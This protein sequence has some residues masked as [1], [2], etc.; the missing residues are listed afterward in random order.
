M[1]E[2]ENLNNKEFYTINRFS[3]TSS[4]LSSNIILS[5]KNGEKA[6]EDLRQKVIIQNKILN[7]YQSWANTLVDILSEQEMTNDHLDLGTPIQERLENIQNLINE[8]LEIKKKIIEHI[9]LNEKLEN[10]IKIKKWNLNNCVKDFNCGDKSNNSIKQTNNIL[11]K[12]IQQMANE[13][14]NLLELKMELDIILGNKDANITLDEII[15]NNTMIFNEENKKIKSRDNSTISSQIIKKD[16]NIKDIIK[17]KEMYYNKKKLIEE[18]E[19]M[20][21]IINMF[22]SDNIKGK[23]RILCGCNGNIKEKNEG[24]DNK[25]D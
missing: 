22:F 5:P 11:E 24:N 12:N 9:Q 23:N 14:D 25:D 10:K 7:E 13:L 19:L 17:I 3:T 20:I 15:S 2:K 1:E 18:N 21:K 16:D 6:F 8:N 4:N